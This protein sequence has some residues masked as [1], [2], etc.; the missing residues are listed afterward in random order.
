MKPGLYNES[1]ESGHGKAKAMWVILWGQISRNTGFLHVLFPKSRENWLKRS[2]LLK[3]MHENQ[4]TCRK[5][6]TYYSNRRRELF[7]I[8]INLLL[9]CAWRLNRRPV[10]QNCACEFKRYSPGVAD[11]IK[12]TSSDTLWEVWPL[13]G[14]K[15]LRSQPRKRH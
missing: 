13:L 2:T 7:K 10:L 6:M 8:W 1:F 15:M 3:W 5:E 11:L 9:D 4:L 12:V 14:S